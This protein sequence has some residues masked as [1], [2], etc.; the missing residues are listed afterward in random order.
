MYSKNPAKYY[1]VSSHKAEIWQENAVVAEKNLQI[2]E[3]Q[4]EEEEIVVQI[5][6]IEIGK[7]IKNA[8]YYI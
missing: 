2:A 6:T 8:T 7:G 5:E 4:I 1:K 3:L